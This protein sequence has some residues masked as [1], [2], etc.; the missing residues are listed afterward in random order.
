MRHQAH[1]FGTFHNLSQPA[2]KEKNGHRLLLPIND[3][4]F[5]K[6]SYTFYKY[7]HF[8][9]SYKF[10]LSTFRENKIFIWHSI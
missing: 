10:E 1:N 2:I 9:F 5:V 7:K 8:I 6:L 3:H 4:L